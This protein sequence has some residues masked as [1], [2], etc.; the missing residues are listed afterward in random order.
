MKNRLLAILETEFRN[1]IIVSQRIIFV[2]KY[3]KI[4]FELMM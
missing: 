4:L 3:T 2:I 1:N